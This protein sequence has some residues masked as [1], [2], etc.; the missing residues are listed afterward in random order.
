MALQAQKKDGSCYPV[1]QP[2]LNVLK[3]AWEKNRE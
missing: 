1:N 2:L 3:K